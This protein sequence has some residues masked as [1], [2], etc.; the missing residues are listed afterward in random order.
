MQ[1]VDVNGNMFGYDHL[2]IIGANGKPKT[3]GGSSSI[4]IGTTPI[5]SGVVGRV[6]FEGTSNVVQESP[7]IFWDIAGNKLNLG[8][9]GVQ[10][11]LVINRASTGGDTGGLKAE[12]T[13]N[14]IHI[15][16]SGY[17]DS[18]NLTNG[19]GV[20]INTWTGSGSGSAE[21]LRITGTTGNVLIN[22]T[23]DSGFKLDVNGTSRFSGLTNFN[24]NVVLNS[25]WLY[26]GP[27][28]GNVLLRPVSTTNL[29]LF[30]NNAGATL[31]LNANG[32]VQIGSTNVVNWATF[33]A[34]GHTIYGTTNT[35]FFS[36]GNIGVN[37]A[38]DAGFKLDVNGTARVQ[39]KLS[40][41]TPT[42][43]SAVMEVTSTTQGFLPPRMTTTEKNAI[44]TPAAGLVVYDTNLSA[45]SS[46][47]GIAWVTLGSGGGISSVT[48]IL[49]GTTGTIVT[50]TTA[51][52][53][54]QS[55]LIP[56]N[57]LAANNTLD[58][59]AR[60]SKTGTAGGGNYRV[61][62]NTS[63][64]LTGATLFG[65]LYTIAGG[66]TIPTHQN[67]RTF[68]YNGTTLSSNMGGVS[69]V[70]DISQSTVAPYTMTYNS[71]TDYYLIFAIQLT[72]TADSSVINGFRVLKYA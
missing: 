16:G 52:T 44:A 63:I 3:T 32:S 46:F 56:A 61:Y 1:V 43:S 4:T 70:T 36:S 27:N 71:A 5:V 19:A 13:G 65:N 39:G 67:Q 60:F 50:G 25:N 69:N 49:I 30:N 64:S 45:L 48:N 53:I 6:L 23:T 72:N 66:A 34:T 18:I 10:G 55:I 2:E 17:V 22:T 38:T 8:S 26:I 62:I 40:V 68:F 51:N 29:Q 42:A 31:F 15:G 37:T 11:E 33:S 47:N 14:G 35:N 9:L 41:N 12:T 21:R 24:A 58:F 59:I 7:S 57:T 54:T 28:N 20:R